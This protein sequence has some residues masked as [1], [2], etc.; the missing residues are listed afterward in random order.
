MKI[1]DL[2]E[3]YQIKEKYILKSKKL[4]IEFSEVEYFLMQLWENHS[5][6]VETEPIPKLR[7]KKQL[8]EKT[9]FVPAERTKEINVPRDIA[10]FFKLEKNN[11]KPITWRY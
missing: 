2:I 5:M 11:L 3:G 9:I 7:P 4:R 8:F 1:K 10:I 6:L